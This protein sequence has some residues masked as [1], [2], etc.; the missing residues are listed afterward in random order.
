[1]KQKTVMMLGA[2]ALQLPAIQYLKKLGCK[3]ILIDYDPEAVGFELGDINLLISTLDQEAVLSAAKKYEPD[4]IMTSTSDGPVRTAAYVNEKLGKTPDL[5]YENAK[6]ATIKTNMRNCLRE[7]D[8]AIPAFQVVEDEASF[9][10]AM[11]KL[12][13]D[14]FLAGRKSVKLVVKPADNAGSRG[15]VLIEIKKDDSKDSFLESYYY[16]K[17]NSRGGVVLVEEFMEGEE[18]SVESMTV[19]G[20]TTVITITDKITTKPPFF[21]EL[22]HVEPSR[23]AAELQDQIKALTV[24]A[25]AAIGLQNG[26]SHTEI[27]LT[28]DGPKIVELAARLGGDFITSKLVP[29]STGVDMVANSVN[30]VL[31]KDISLDKSRDCGAAICFIQSKKGKIKEITVADDLKKAEGIEEIVIYKKPGDEIEETTSSNHR[32]GHVIATGRDGDEALQRAR[33]VLNQIQIRIEGC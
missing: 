4:F 12:T 28:K 17:D 1:M 7:H 18:V 29:L 26:P 22:G 15:V 13:K 3:V 6:C 10:N 9:L 21:V 31:G 32:L 25:V 20:V 19:N 16:S 27:K 5:S 24:K 30:L 2:S 8:V 23:H 11:E 14:D 33:K